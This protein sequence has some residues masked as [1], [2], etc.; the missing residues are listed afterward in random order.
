MEIYH[1]KHFSLLDAAI[2]GQLEVARRL[3]R[4]G[5]DLE[6][7]SAN[8][9]TALLN[10]VMHCN[11]EIVKLL[12]EAGADVNARK[13]P[14]QI[15][16]LM[17]ACSNGDDQISELLLAAD[18]KLDMMD[19]SGNTAFHYACFASSLDIIKKIDEVN[20]KYRHV[21]NDDGNT[22]LL[23]AA[24]EGR[25]GVVVWLLEQGASLTDRNAK[26]ETVVG[27]LITAIDDERIDELQPVW[28]LILE[29]TLNQ[30]PQ[31]WLKACM[32]G[33]KEWIRKMLDQDISINMT[34]SYGN[35]GLHYAL[36]GEH[37]DTVR[38]LLKNQ[39]DPAL[40]SEDGTTPEQ[41][42]QERYQMNIESYAYDS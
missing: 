21:P 11:P 6:E 18:A 27:Q 31:A 40:P 36:A 19:E 37:P 35:S 15:T 1:Q 34:D 4:E 12:V 26:G 16:P 14:E 30:I 7:R 3:I 32:L 25:P 42:C 22:P 8:G 23:I 5:A 10:A 41:L 38:I 2:D 39:A 13:T 33:R 20:S 28:P 24:R 29:E 17:I 9:T